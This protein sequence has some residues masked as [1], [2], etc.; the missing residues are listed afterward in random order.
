MSQK[1]PSKEEKDKRGE[2]IKV[3]EIA[4]WSMKT[5]EPGKSIQMFVCL[6]III[7][8]GKSVTLIGV[9]EKG[10]FKNDGKM[11]MKRNLGEFQTMIIYSK[12]EERSLYM[13]IAKAFMIKHVS[14]KHHKSETGKM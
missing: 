12:T 13:C 11:L 7:L 9:Q 1:E 5:E 8:R 4:D 3:Q 2:S 10:A 6:N 14:R